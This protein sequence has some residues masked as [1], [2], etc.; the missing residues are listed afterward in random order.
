MYTIALGREISKKNREERVVY[1]LE[2]ESKDFWGF[3]QYITFSDE[4]HYDPDEQPKRHILREQGTRLDPDNMQIRPELH[5]IRLHYSASCSWHYKSEL[6]FYND[7][8]DPPTVKPVL[9]PRPRRRP[10]TETP[11]QYEQRLEDWKEHLPHNPEIKPKGNLMTQA[12]YV[13]KILS[14]LIEQI[15]ELRCTLPEHGGDTILQEDN[16]PSHGKRSG[17]GGAANKLRT[18][19]WIYTLRHP[20]QSPDLSPIEALWAILKQRVRRRRRP[21]IIDEMKQALREEWEQITMEEVRRRIQEMPSRCRQLVQN[22]GR[23]IKS[24][25]W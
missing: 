8:Y 10:T 21:H 22:K 1:G 5:G 13:E 19:N 20:A 16:D 9:P 23:A 14:G 2:N 4:A 7:E 24:D 6:T 15:Q 25:L 18:A 12:Y 17:L 11:E 3:W